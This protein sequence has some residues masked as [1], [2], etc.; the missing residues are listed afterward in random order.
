M[1]IDCHCHIFDN[2]CVPLNGMVASRFGIAIGNKI[3]KLI[4]DIGKGQSRGPWRDYL[5]DFSIDLKSIRS[6]IDP[7]E[8]DSLRAMIEHRKDFLSFLTIGIQD[9]PWI[10]DRMVQS[11]A[12]IDIWVPLMMNMSHAYP[13][14]Q[15]VRSFESQRELM[16]KLP[17][18]SRGRIMPFYAFDP[19]AE[20]SVE[21]MKTA[22]ESQGFVGVKL[23][24]PLGYKPIGNDDPEMEDA[25][26]LLY[27]YCCKNIDYPIPITAH[28]SWSA[29][30]YSN[31]HVPGI[32]NIKKYYRN[33]A[34]PS[35]WEEV[36]DKFP[37][38][39]LNLAH[40][41]GLGE[42][43]AMAKGEGPNEKW[44]D[45]I[46]TLIKNH[47]NIYTDLSFHGISTT[48][49]ADDYKK[50]LLEKINGIKNKILLGSD[51]YMSRMQCS[52]KDYW[53]GF[54]T[55]IPELYDMAT[56]E[57]AISF[58]TSDATKNY[59]PQYFES[60][61]SELKEQYRNGFRSQGE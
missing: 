5:K 35:H 2:D 57:N 49:L 20:N 40:F 59:F 46:I 12:E 17:L 24:P 53:H 38:L 6:L 61:N 9:M 43:E 19:R 25:L 48:D 47:D 29:G 26:M 21:K 52:L 8:K 32:T 33:M 28:C 13:G 56:G 60:N 42:W 14:S 58:L 18:K 11:A 36:L 31:K 4:A 45:P 7:Q 50:I 1:R 41:G 55:L 27:D 3:L 23:Y 15:P 37:K 16:S 10:L 51:W 30:V 34:K 39:K 44:I 54:E 22:I